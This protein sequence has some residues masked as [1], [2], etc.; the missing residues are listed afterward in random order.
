MYQMGGHHAMKAEN[1][2]TK[3]SVRRVAGDTEE[4]TIE[5]GGDEKRTAAHR[6][7]S[8]VAFR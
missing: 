2:V 1:G 5:I 7:A 6:A 4:T 8:M 3:I